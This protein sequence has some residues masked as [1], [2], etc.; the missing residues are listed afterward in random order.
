[1]K[2]ALIH[3]HL[4]NRGG[5]Q[6]YVL[7]IAKVLKSLGIVVDI[8]CYEYNQ[9][10]C[11]PELTKNLNIKDVLSFTKRNKKFD[12]SKNEKFLKK[13]IKKLYNNKLIYRICIGLGLDYLYSLYLNIKSS[14]QVAKLILESQK[15][16][17]LIF[18]HEEPL[19]IYSA[20]E[21]KKIKKIPIYWFCYD[22][23][24]KW[25]LEWNTFDKYSNLRFFL[26][27]KLYFKYDKYFI[28]R[29]V[30]TAAVLDKNM[31]KR[32]I[33]L[34]NKVPLIRYGGICNNVLELKRANLIRDKY[35]LSSEIKIIFSL[36]RFEPYKRPH[37]IFELYESL[38]DD[39][40]N[41]VFVYLNS[42]ISN[43]EYYK[44]CLKKYKKIFENSNVVIDLNYP[45]NDKEMYD[46]FLSS[47]IFI[48]PNEK[49]TW[50]HAALEA[51]ACGVATIISDGSG[52]SNVLKKNSPEMI[53]NVG[54]IDKLK[55]IIEKLI[56]NKTYKISGQVQKKFVR[57]NLTWER[58]CNQYI[59]D[60]NNILDKKL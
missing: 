35:N 29:F 9:N 49:Q 22:T 17:D 59:N 45:K 2:I 4:D 19:S 55:I 43:Q 50:G 14:K 10:L 57:D 40:K 48:Y 8:F 56:K 5:S 58:V 24:E 39:V 52:I 33:N 6:R 38:S 28:N 1:M 53:Y 54:K 12:L 47:D 30:D 60:F 20:I 3:S 51:M 16:Y 25:F 18:A 21:Y 32:F 13:I 11:Y 44:W 37:D 36:T 23:I 7:E 26:L 42:P 27:K 46:L 31:K 41:K 15:E 34:Y